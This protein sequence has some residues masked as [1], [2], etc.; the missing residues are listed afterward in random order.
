MIYDPLSLHQCCYRF[1]YLLFLLFNK[2]KSVFHASVLLLVMNFVM[3]LSMQLMKFIVN[4]DRCLKTDFNLF[5]IIQIIQ[6]SK[7]WCSFYVFSHDGAFRQKAY[8][9]MWSV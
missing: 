4:N 5:F 6:M 7:R 2:V 8:F 9:P 3:T 1:E